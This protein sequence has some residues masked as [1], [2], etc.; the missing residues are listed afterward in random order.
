MWFG[1]V[2]AA[3]DAF[4]MGCGVWGVASDD[5]PLRQGKRRRNYCRNFGSWKKEEKDTIIYVLIL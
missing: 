3:P 5:A 1:G 4:G 2:A